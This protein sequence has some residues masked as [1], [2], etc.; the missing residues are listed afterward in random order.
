[1]AEAKGL[2]AEQR[3]E[4]ARLEARLKDLLRRKF[5]D[6]WHPKATPGRDVPDVAGFQGEIKE[7]FD[8]IRSIDKKYKI[9]YFP[10]HEG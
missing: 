5:K 6:Y 10:L 9:P 2:D 7:V 1:M 8:S 3:Q 4:L